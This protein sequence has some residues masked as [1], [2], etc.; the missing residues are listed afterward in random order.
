LFHT[1][2]HTMFSDKHFTNFVSRETK[3]VLLFLALYYFL[4]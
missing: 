3:L 2:F 1:L 4:A